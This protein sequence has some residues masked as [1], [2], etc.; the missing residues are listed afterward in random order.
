MKSST[1]VIKADEIENVVERISP[2]PIS[3]SSEK[4][5]GIM[6]T[7]T[8]DAVSAPWIPQSLAREA[9][10]LHSLSGEVIKTE[11]ADIEA[12]SWLPG[13]ISIL[14]ERNPNRGDRCIPHPEIV[15]VW[16]KAEAQAEEILQAAQTQAM[17][18]LQQART[19][20]LAAAETE[21]REMVQAAMETLQMATLV[22]ESLLAGSEGQVLDLV[23]SIARKLFGKGFELEPE[24]LRETFKKAVEEAKPHGDLRLHLNPKDM[25][26]IGPDWL[27]EQAVL[28][29]K[30]I[31]YV[32]DNNI[33][34]GGCFIEGK[35]GNV[36]ARVGTQLEQIE[37][38]L[39]QRDISRR[40]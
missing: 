4:T 9:H 12:N 1:N 15:D 31:E 19:E 22:R 17:E 39:T 5:G 37:K 8:G 36:D 28:F 21:T 14:E 16:K 27:E 25:E 40:G 13:E 20:G 38:T 35:F 6:E 23:V 11:E 34:R 7:R 29:G 2:F 26:K 18:I 33:E 32:P 10:F 30:G 3:T 24:V